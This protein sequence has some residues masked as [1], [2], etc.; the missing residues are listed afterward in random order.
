[1]APSESGVDRHES[2]E[3][4]HRG[5]DRLDLLD[6]TME[7]YVNWRDESRAV[8]EC[9][10]TWSLAVGRERDAAFD[11]YVAALDREEHAACGYRRLVDPRPYGV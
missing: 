8:A 5:A 6:A 7:S 10:R 2:E 1:M 11:R 4:P 3:I 9:Y